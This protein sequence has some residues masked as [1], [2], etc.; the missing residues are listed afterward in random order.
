MTHPELLKHIEG[1]G[2]EAEILLLEPRADYDQFIVGV[3][4]RGAEIVVLYD[5]DALLSWLASIAGQGDDDDS[6]DP[7]E[8]AEEHFSFNMSQ[9][10]PGYPMFVSAMLEPELPDI[11]D[12]P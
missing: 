7:S 4:E 11:D 10:G 5:K 3:A 2:E 1:L 6:Q 12:D 9:A 8:A